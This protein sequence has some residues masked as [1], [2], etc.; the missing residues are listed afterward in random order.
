MRIDSDLQGAI[1]ADAA[2]SAKVSEEEVNAVTELFRKT[3]GKDNL[4]VKVEPLKSEKISAVITEN[5]STRRLHDMIRLYS[6]PGMGGMKG[7]E[8]EESLTLNSNNALVRFLLDHSD[9]EHVPVICRQLYDLARISR[10]RLEADEMTEFVARSN[11]VLE[12]LTR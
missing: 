9:S 4:T 6:G 8:A 11:E 12:L 2:T 7:M 3:L 1:K 10:G 5:E